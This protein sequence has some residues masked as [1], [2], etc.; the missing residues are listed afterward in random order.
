MSSDDGLIIKVTA[1]KCGHYVKL[2]TP[3]SVVYYC[4]EC[5]NAMKKRK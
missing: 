3:F 1:K 5:K 2:N 4:D